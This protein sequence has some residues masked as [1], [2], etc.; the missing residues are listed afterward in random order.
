[1]A[2]SKSSKNNL[3]CFSG[4]EDPFQQNL[5][6]INDSLMSLFE[7]HHLRELLYPDCMADFVGLNIKNLFFFHSF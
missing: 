1:M 3:I 6:L 2:D 5:L 7:R 4:F